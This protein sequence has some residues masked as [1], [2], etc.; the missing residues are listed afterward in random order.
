MV[1]MPNAN[2][3]VNLYT[4]NSRLSGLDTYLKTKGFGW[5]H[6]RNLTLIEKIEKNNRMCQASKFSQKSQSSFQIW[7]LKS[8]LFK[9]VFNFN[10]VQNRHGR[11]K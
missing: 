9:S 6:N 8:F 10:S 4:E 1:F 3:N 2:N 5:A 7:S 11:L